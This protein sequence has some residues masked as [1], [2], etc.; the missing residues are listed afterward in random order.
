MIPGD[1]LYTNYLC[2][3][4]MLLQGAAY[5]DCTPNSDFISVKM[6]YC[7]FFFTYDD[8]KRGFVV[9]N[10]YGEKNVHPKIKSLIA[11]FI[12]KGLKDSGIN[13]TEIIING[14]PVKI[15][16][17]TLNLLFYLG[18]IRGDW[19]LILPPKCGKNCVFKK[20]CKINEPVDINRFLRVREYVLD[21]DRHLS[22]VTPFIIKNDDLY[23]ASLDMIEEIFNP[24]HTKNIIN[25]I[26]IAKK[27]V[28]EDIGYE[29]A[30]FVFNLAYRI[31]RYEPLYSFTVD[32]SKYEGYLTK[33]GKYII[34]SDKFWILV[35]GESM[36]EDIEKI[37]S[38]C[39]GIIHNEEV[40]DWD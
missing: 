14:E 15:D 3:I 19:D 11:A 7:V 21:P 37:Y 18:R 1:Y 23:S 22:Y 6:G 26:I 27:T 25:N 28:I 24:E 12:Y 16:I 40:I 2:R 34:P 36:E 13:S 32:I 4:N 5:S 39:N 17:E 31:L 38:N 9:K 35:F 30:D 10:Q 8:E 29:K 20:I 33:R